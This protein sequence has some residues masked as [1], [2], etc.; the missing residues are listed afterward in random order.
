VTIFGADFGGTHGNFTVYLANGG[1]TPTSV[2]RT[3]TQA[4]FS[5]PAL[6]DTTTSISV[7]VNVGGYNATAS[8]LFFTGSF[9]SSGF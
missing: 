1:V 6:S 7:A 9:V 4:V 8:T 2:T 5:V 3:H